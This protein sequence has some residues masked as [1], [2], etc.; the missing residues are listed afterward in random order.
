M[1]AIEIIDTNAG[2]I[3][4]YGMCGYKNIKQEGYRRKIEWV[5]QRFPEG[6]KYKILYSDKD[7][8][9][10][11]IEYIPGEY[12]WRP[13][14]ARGYMVIHCIYII[15]RKYKGQGYGS[16]LVEEC[17]EDARKGHMHGVAVVTRNG[18]WMVSK[19]LFVKNGFDVVDTAPPDFE[20][21]VK[22]I[23]GNA[24]SPKFKGD[25]ERRLSQYDRGLVIFSSDQCPYLPI[26][27]LKA[28][29]ETAENTYGIKPHIVELK[30]CEEAQ[31]NSPCAFG[32][33]CIAYDAKVIADHPISNTR[34]INIMNKIL[35]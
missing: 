18:T 13:V 1:E 14:E 24:P 20:L 12:A 16:L 11:G 5:K 2:N 6:M 32:T 30:N 10:G 21:L 29:S 9:L 22:K 3:H 25:W 17:S 27:A 31:N 35:K 26:K 7:G 23:S 4:Q 34:F 19:E 28:I 33:F 8:A 15:P